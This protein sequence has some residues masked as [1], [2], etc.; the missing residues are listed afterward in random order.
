[1]EWE[2]Q[3]RRWCFARI[4]LSA[5][6]ALLA[7]G[8]GRSQAPEPPP[9]ESKDYNEL[10]TRAR[11]RQARDQRLERI[12][13]AIEEYQRQLG[14]PPDNLVELVR[15]GFLS[16]LPALP[17]GYE[18]RYDSVLGVVEEIDRLSDPE[19]LEPAAAPFGESAPPGAFVPLDIGGSE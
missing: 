8:C 14:G 19:V 13:G 15:G 10:L 3:K 2:T 12:R 6:L 16:A 9:S 4:W 5:G 17:P 18:Y 1:M 11:D 7:G